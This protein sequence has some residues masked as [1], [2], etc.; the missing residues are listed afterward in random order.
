M[1][2]LLGFTDE[3]EKVISLYLDEKAAPVDKL[4]RINERIATMLSTNAA[5]QGKLQE[6]EIICGELQGSSS[7]LENNVIEQ[8]GQLQQ[9]KSQEA[10]L[11]KQLQTVYQGQRSEELRMRNA[12]MV[13]EERLNVLT[14]ENTRLEEQ[15]R[16]E[17]T[18]LDE[19]ATRLKGIDQKLAYLTERKA[20]LEPEELSSIKSESCAQSV[21]ADEEPIEVPDVPA[22]VPEASAPVEVPHEGVS[23]PPAN[24]FPQAP[25]VASSSSMLPKAPVA[26]PPPPEQ[27]P[28]GRR[29]PQRNNQR[30]SF[31]NK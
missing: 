18:L 24:P 13:L 30:G 11:T 14:R 2:N 16:E 10:E 25:G 29:R 8:D 19:N 3:E 23:V 12:V 17:E 26:A 7:Q 4:R 31:S 5:L 22:D 20:A 1:V 9:Y 28:T 27:A 21:L 6:Q 15:R